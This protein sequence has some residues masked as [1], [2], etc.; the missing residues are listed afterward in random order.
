MIRSSFIRTVM[1]GT[2]VFLCMLFTFTEISYTKPVTISGLVTIKSSVREPAPDWAVMQRHLID[3][4]N[5]AGP[6]YLDKWTNTGGTM[7][8]HGKFDDDL[9][10]FT[11][12]PLFYLIGGDDRFLDWSHQQ[13]SAITRQWTFQHLKS[14][15]KEFPKHYDMLHTSEGYVGFQ[16]LCLADPTIPENIDRARR[17]A[18]F[19]LNEDPDIESPNY[20]PKLKIIRSI[21]TG[22]AGAADHQNCWYWLTFK[23]PNNPL[24]HSSLYPEVIVDNLEPGWYKNIKSFN[25][26]QEIYDRIVTPCDIPLNLATTGLVSTAYIM[27]GDNKYKQWVLDYVD[28]WMERIEE[29]NGIIPDNIGRTGKIGEYRNGQWW[30]GFL[31]WNTNSGNHI[32]FHALITAAECAYII[33]G[34][35]KYLDL[36]RSQAVMILDMSVV[37]NGQLLVPHHYSPEGWI[38]YRPM[39]PYILSHLWHASMDSG[40]WALIEKLQKGSKNGIDD[41]NKTYSSTGEDVVIRG[42]SHTVNE[43]AHLSFLGGTFPEWPNQILSTEYEQIV[44]NVKR[45]HNKLDQEELDRITRD[46][47]DITNASQFPSQ[48]L[49]VQN[50][51]F[52]NGLAQMTMGAPFTCFNGGLLRA[53]VRYY[54]MDR[55]RPGLPGNVAALVEKLEAEKTIINLVNTSEQ[56]T[57]RL[58][59]QAG[60]YREHDFTKVTFTTVSNDNKEIQEISEKTVQVNNQYFAVELPPLTSIKMSIGTKRFV[61]RPTCAFPW[62]N[63]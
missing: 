15:H 48:L 42:N 25:E 23:Y 54:D 40:D 17:F 60:A 62:Y 45:L 49:L 47:L 3:T 61:N 46:N 52:T 5:E 4:M 1:V 29:N 36:L 58:I 56:E 13:F 27:T 51:I 10:C 22:S 59:I 16:Y 8:A 9:E 30:G 20:D 33:S 44:S 63:Q 37:R 19:Y 26:I 2:V 31:G 38:D 21:E 28:A 32:I 43:A 7:R 12:W 50:P 39:R 35:P 18:G 24:Y 34:D 6:L 11:S 53:R 41:W 57:R 55:T 14:V